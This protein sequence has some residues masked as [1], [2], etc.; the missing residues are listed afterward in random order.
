MFFSPVIQP[1]KK[2]SETGKPR[3]TSKNPRDQS[4]RTRRNPRDYRT[5]GFYSGTNRFRGG[6][7]GFRGGERTRFRGGF[8]NRPRFDDRRMRPPMPG[9]EYNSVNDR[10]ICGLVVIPPM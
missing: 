3:F 10:I 5:S 7:F 4:D 2:E 9:R 8:I 1:E 6:G